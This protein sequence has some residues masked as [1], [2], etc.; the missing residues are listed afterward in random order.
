MALRMDGDWHVGDGPADL[1]AFLREIGAEGY[2]VHEV[3]H[4]GCG[5]C[6]AGVFGVAGDPAEGAMRRT[7]RECGA[8]Q[9]VAGSED[10]WSEDETQVM[11][12]VCEGEHFDVAIGYSL[13]PN[14]AGVRSLATAERCVACGKIGSFTQW[15]VRG[16][17]LELLDQA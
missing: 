14:G 5:E 9:F 13:Y 4:S 16:G 2:D 17:E 8:E 10:Y 6:G 3:R 15:M 7:C 1:E 11:V 12:C